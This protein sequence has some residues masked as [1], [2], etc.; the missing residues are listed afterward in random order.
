MILTRKIL[1]RNILTNAAA[2]QL[3]M[4][5]ILLL[6]HALLPLSPLLAIL[7]TRTLYQIN[8]LKGQANYISFGMLGSF[9]LGIR[10]LK[11]FK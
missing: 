8:T 1:T 9:L 10:R 2:F 4:H 11:V 6:L 7:H 5:I 3:S